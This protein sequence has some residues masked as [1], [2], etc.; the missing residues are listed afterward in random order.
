MSSLLGG[1]LAPMLY[2]Q[3]SYIVDVATRGSNGE[4]RLLDL[5]AKIR[6][7]INLGV[8]GMQ[9]IGTS[10]VFRR[11]GVPLASTLSP[12][13]Y[14]LG[15]LGVSTRLDLPSGI[16]AVG[17]ANLQDHAIQEPAQKIL[18]TLFPER[19][20]AA[21][22]SLVE[23]PVQRAGGS[24]GNILVLCGLAIANPAAVGFAA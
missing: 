14:L 20:R 1:I 6:G 2:F 3:F 9:L 19:V 23:G 18:A 15:F 4:M 22:T 10:R 11:I 13:V 7:F 8:L 17:S 16:G 12:L 21:A 5:Y 24:L